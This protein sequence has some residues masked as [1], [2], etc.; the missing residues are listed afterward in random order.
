MRYSIFEILG[1]ARAWVPAV[2]YLAATTTVSYALWGAWD[3]VDPTWN[4]WWFDALLLGFHVL[5]GVAVRRWWSLALP[6]VW[7]LV[8]IPAGGYDT[9]VAIGVLFQTPFFWSPA[10]ALGVAIGKV[11]FGPRARR[12]LEATSSR[13]ARS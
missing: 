11:G 13:T 1:R 6:L 9:P 10:L 2:A 8:S 3:G 12:P 5:I 7:A 4:S